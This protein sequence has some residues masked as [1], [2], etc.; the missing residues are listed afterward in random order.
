MQLQHYKITSYPF[1]ALKAWPGVC[2]SSTQVFGGMCPPW[3]HAPALRAPPSAPPPADAAQRAPW[4]SEPPCA[5]Q[6]LP[7]PMP[8]PVHS[9]AFKAWS[10]QSMQRMHLSNTEGAMMSPE[11]INTV[12]LL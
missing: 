7:P 3:R 8:S 12:A 6:P 5:W 10:T 11:T 1:V 2:H 4:L 9:T